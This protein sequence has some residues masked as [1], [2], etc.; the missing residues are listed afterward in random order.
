MSKSKKE[1]FQVTKKDNDGK[2]KET[3]YAVLT[4]SPAD[5]REAQ[6]VYNA[7]F[8]AALSSGGLLRKRVGTYMRE[9]GLWDDAKEAE[10]KDLAHSINEMELKI[11]AGNIKLTTARELAIDMRRARFDM[12]E[13]L[14]Q[15]N[16]LDVS[17]VEGQAENARFN[18]LVSRCLVYNE[19][20]KPVYADMDDYLENGDAEEAWT[21]AEKLAKML[22]QLDKYSEHKLPEN[23]FLTRW[24]FIDEELRLV[25][26]DGHL[27]DT[28]GRFI[29]ADG[30]YVDE[31]DELIDIEGRP[32]DDKGNYRVEQAPF[33][34]DD[35]KP[36]AEPEV[37][38]IAE[39]PVKPKR[40]RGRPSKA[41]SVSSD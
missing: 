21:G 38:T 11:Q 2:T 12:R 28:E 17:T 20:G 41:S 33:L 7:T 37:D 36:L 5:G 24:K 13:L 10:Y 14:A 29:N 1:T 18:V 23:Q 35:G 26:K 6:K 15:K 32:V 27:V 39:A 25:N 9:Q 40:K 4:P 16:E 3:E 31:N 8:S 22:Y 19:T 30:H 34:D